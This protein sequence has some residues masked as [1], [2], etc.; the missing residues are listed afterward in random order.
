MSGVST[1]TALLASAVIGAGAS[2]AASSMNKPPKQTPTALMPTLNND[3]IRK[4]RAG[5]AAS[6]MARSGRQ[7]TLLSSPVKTPALGAVNTVLTT[8][9]VSS[10]L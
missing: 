2:Y 10:N 4:K 5:D 6:L 3:A 1:G 8:P 7:S 9:G